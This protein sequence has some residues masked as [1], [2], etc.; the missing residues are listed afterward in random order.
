M[1]LFLKSFILTIL[2]EGVTILFRYGFN[3]QSTRDTASTIGRMTFG[4]RVHHGYIGILIIIIA[5]YYSQQNSYQEW[6]LAVGIALLLSDLIHHFL[7]LWPIEG[8]PQFD[9]FYPR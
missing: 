4:L 2:F 8:D 3:L 1:S 7:V 9:R 5:R 6:I